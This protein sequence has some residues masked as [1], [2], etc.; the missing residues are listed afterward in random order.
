[1]ADSRVLVP[2]SDSST[3][4]ATVAH[5]VERV[6]AESTVADPGTVR[7]VYVHPEEAAITAYDGSV[8][9][10]EAVSPADALLNRAEVWVEEDAGEEIDAVRVETAQ[11]GEDEYLFSPGEVAQVIARDAVSNDIDRVILDPEYKP[12]VGGPFLRP[13]ISELETMLAIPVEEAPVTRS[14]IRGP[15][16]DRFTPTR[17]GVLFGLSFLFYQVL[18]GSIYWFDLVTGAMSATVVTV[19]LSRVSL[20]RT[21][22]L[23]SPIRV[24]RAIIYVPYLLAEIVKSNLLVAAVILHPRL[25]I[26]PR[27][28]RIR[29][30]VHGSMPITTLANSITLTPG[31][32]TV[33][34]HGRTM[35]VHTLVE[36]AREGLFYGDLERAVRF[37]FYG[38]RAMR[39]ESLRDRGETEI[40][41]SPDS[42]PETA[43]TDGGHPDSTDEP[44]ADAADED[45]D[46]T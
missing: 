11:V 26:D 39:I 29:P 37:L 28:T 44:A 25:P 24:L 34:V 14:T 45:G 12:G 20:T 8:S 1:M 42:E 9:D 4:R 10:E 38:R 27:L 33:R 36:D 43:M 2:L 32:L 23:Q 19:A 7:F 3:V 41:Q 18:G 40:L 22:D 17:A 16:I 5:A 6:L 31:T 21:P 15:L 46:P 13:F 35:I 30:A